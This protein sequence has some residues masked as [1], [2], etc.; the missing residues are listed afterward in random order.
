MTILLLEAAADNP[1]ASELANKFR[2]ITDEAE[3]DAPY[4]ELTCE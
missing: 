3:D 4:D 1:T 2:K